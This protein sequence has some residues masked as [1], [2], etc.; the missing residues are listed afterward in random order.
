[1]SNIVVF[2]LATKKFI[3]AWKKALKKILFVENEV[4]E[5]VIL[6]Q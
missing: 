6:I 4:D 2:R 5:F 3:R 1:M